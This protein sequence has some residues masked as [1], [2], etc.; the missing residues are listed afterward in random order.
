MS[1]DTFSK[2]FAARTLGTWNELVTKSTAAIEQVYSF[3]VALP[4]APD[5]REQVKRLKPLAP[6]AWIGASVAVAALLPSLI[7]LWKPVLGTYVTVLALAC[8][9]AL[10]VKVTKARKLMIAGSILPVASMV[11]LSLPAT[12]NALVRVSVQYAVLLLLGASYAYMFKKDKPVRKARVGLKRYP[13]VLPIM[14]IIGEVLG[15][16]GYGIL[17]HTYPYKGDLLPILVGAAIAFAVTEEVF[18]RGLIQRQS[19]KVMHPVTAAG[20]T[21]VAYTAVTIGL[22]SPLPTLFA[23]LSGVTLSSIY[24]YKPNLV[25][26]TSANIAMKLTY[27]GLVAT[28]VLH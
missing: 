21:V 26:T 23:L 11:S 1:A 6:N 16:A 22:G 5:I 27:V 24:Y 14:V 4:D 12:T 18:F 2:N 17:R 10:A 25:L 9:L 19:T 13:S 28:F 3:A 20:A 15:L 8:L 7:L